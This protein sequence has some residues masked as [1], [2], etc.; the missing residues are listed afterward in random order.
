[1]QRGLQEAASDYRV[2]TGLV[3]TYF[4][5]LA[6]A[7]GQGAASPP[8]GTQGASF[9]EGVLSTW[10]R[11]A[12]AYGETGTPGGPGPSGRPPAGHAGEF[13]LR[14]EGNMA[15]SN[16]V[17]LERR[18]RA[19]ASFRDF[20]EG[21]FGEGI[22]ALVQ[23]RHAGDGKLES[24]A[25]VR[26]S[27]HDAF[28]DFALETASASAGKVGAAPRPLLGV[29]A[30][31]FRTLWSFEGRVTFLTVKKPREL[32]LRDALGAAAMLALNAVT[33]TTDVPRPRDEEGTLIGH[34]SPLTG[35]GEPLDTRHGSAPFT[36][37]FEEARGE[38]GV[39]DLTQPR[40]DVRVKLLAVE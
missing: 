3:D 6:S 20:A 7:L 14:A 1:V 32:T 17:D 35:S 40:F 18:Q 27:G 31:G 28:D 15:A 2:R 29:D 4:A 10:S 8:P 26:S 5:E 34:A 25:L 19:G 12:K 24:L 33:P 37:R 9:V 30:A 38:V 11:A 16:L 39:V 21:R 23:L 36:G 22:V 13:S